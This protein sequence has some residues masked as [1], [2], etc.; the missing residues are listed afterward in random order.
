[1]KFE[2]EDIAAGPHWLWV[3]LVRPQSGRKRSGNSGKR[4]DSAGRQTTAQ[5]SSSGICAGHSGGLQHV[6]KVGVAGSNPVVRSRETPGQGRW[7]PAL[8]HVRGRPKC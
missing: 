6:A 5:S 3:A 4:C 8:L 7:E 1:M 2:R